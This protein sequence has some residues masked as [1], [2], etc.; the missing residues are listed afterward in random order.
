M[1]AFRGH[2]AASRAVPGHGTSTGVMGYVL[3]SS[4]LFFAPKIS[5]V[6]FKGLG[7]F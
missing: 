1:A 4:S 2:A 3:T 7:F 5:R 6:R